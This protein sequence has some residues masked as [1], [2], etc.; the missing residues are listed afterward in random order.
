[1]KGFA[2]VEFIVVITIFASLML[3]ATISLSTVKQQASLNTSIAILLADLKQQ[4]LKAMVGETEGRSYTDSYGLH[5]G[6]ANYVLFHG[7]SYSATDAAN[8]TINL[9][10]SIAVASAPGEI[11]FSQLSGNATG[12]AIITLRD[13]TTSFQKSVIMNKY[14]VV[15]DVH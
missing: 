14:G 11:V 9:G 5:F 7:S 2:L 15:T 3:I 4:Q 13:S 1:M 8:L 12:S 10:D 6:T